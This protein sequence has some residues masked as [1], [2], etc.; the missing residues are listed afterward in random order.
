M[1]E[2]TVGCQPAEG[3]GLI[4][5]NNGHWRDSQNSKSLVSL[6]KGTKGPFSIVHCVIFCVLYTSYISIFSNTG[7]RLPKFLGF[8][9]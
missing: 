6:I 4:K 8:L 3:L 9:R 5:G 7:G 1:V 2:I